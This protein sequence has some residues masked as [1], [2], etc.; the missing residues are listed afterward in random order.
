MRANILGNSCKNHEL[1]EGKASSI[2]QEWLKLAERN[3]STTEEAVKCAGRVAPRPLLGRWGTASRCEAFLLRCPLDTLHKVWNRVFAFIPEAAA[4]GHVGGLDELAAEETKAYQEKMGRWARDAGRGLHD[5][6][7]WLTL[8]LSK[9]L[10]ESLDHLLHFLMQNRHGGPLN[11]SVL[12]WGKAA[13][14][15]EHICKLFE[16]DQ[17]TE[18]LSFATKVG[19]HDVMRGCIRQELFSMLAD[20]DRRIMHRVTLSPYD[21]LWFA[22]KPHDQYCE[23]RKLIASKLLESDETALHV[24]ACKV[25]QLFPAAVKFAAHSGKVPLQLYA[26]F[27]RFTINLFVF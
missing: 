7:F 19:L 24:T 22:Y 6:R 4:A 1:L 25:K 16:P 5:D 12:V 26:I 11:L 21:L 2:Y 9:K 18:L 3:E 20:Y 27:R 13:E 15:R 10:K 17:W 14:I 8:Q 23:Q